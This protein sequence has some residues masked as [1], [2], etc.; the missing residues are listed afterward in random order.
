MKAQLIK[1]L[2]ALQAGGYLLSVYSGDCR[3][4]YGYSRISVLKNNEMAWARQ[5]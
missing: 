3:G 2:V 1:Q 4:C 5:F